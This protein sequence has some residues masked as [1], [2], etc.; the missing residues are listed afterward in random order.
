MDLTTW[1]PS[2]A[3][4]VGTAGDSLH[5][6][7]NWCLV[8][9]PQPGPWWEAG[10][11]TQPPGPAGFCP[12]KEIP[13]SVSR[14]TGPVMSLGK[15]TVLWGTGHSLTGSKSR[16][17]SWQESHFHCRLAGS[18]QAA[19]ISP[20]TSTRGGLSLQLGCRMHVAMTALPVSW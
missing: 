20:R 3:T 17:C 16:V 7:S 4:H 12:P 18:Q 15:D 1:C 8:P 19:G 9:Q 13:L 2:G 5:T 14:G 11:R 6:P 10:V